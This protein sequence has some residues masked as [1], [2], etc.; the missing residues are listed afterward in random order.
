ME[1][2][3]GPDGAVLAGLVIFTPS[4]PDP[5]ATYCVTSGSV[6][7]NGSDLSSTPQ[8]NSAGGLR[9]LG[10]CAEA[11]VLDVC[12]AMSIAWGK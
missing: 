11:P 10:T 9:R 3:F 8:T 4:G 1:L 2:W 12:D 6:S 7:F 5:G